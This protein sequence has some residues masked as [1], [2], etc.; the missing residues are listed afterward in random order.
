MLPV[1]QKPSESIQIPLA[2]SRRMLIITSAVT[3]PVAREKNC[4][5]G[6]Y[7]RQFKRPSSDITTYDQMSYFR[8]KL[9]CYIANIIDNHSKVWSQ[10][11]FMFLMQVPYAYQAAFI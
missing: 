11:D 9:V 5:S 1:V 7:D 8:Y 2:L 6:T 4:V 10:E 3:E